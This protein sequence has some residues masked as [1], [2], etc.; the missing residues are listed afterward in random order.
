MKKF[1]EVYDNV[2]PKELVKGYKNLLL[3]GKND[4]IQWS[5]KTNISENTSYNFPGFS[6]VFFRKNPEFSNDYSNY[7]N[8]ILNIFCFNR[9]IQIK[10][11]TL[12][13]IFLQLPYY[14]DKTIR[15]AIHIDSTLSHWVCLYYV[16]NS[17]GDTIFYDNNKKEIKRISPKKG[18]IVFFD[19]SIFHSAN[20]SSKKHRAVINFNFTGKIL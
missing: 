9:N 7:F 19:G 18:R 16:N 11:I 4:Y 17:D 1:I 13:R 14:K 20:S 5:Y 3:S 15:S 2:I 12:G 10:D 6:H 8:Q